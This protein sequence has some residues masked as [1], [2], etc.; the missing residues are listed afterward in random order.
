MSREFFKDQIK[1]MTIGPGRLEGLFNVDP[2][3]EILT[4]N[5]KNLYFSGILFPKSNAKAPDDAAN[6]VVENQDSDEEPIDGVEDA[7]NEGN[8]EEKIER[9]TTSNAD[10][11]LERF[12]PY[13]IGMVFQLADNCSQIK[14]SYQYAKYESFDNLNAKRIRFSQNEKT[15]LDEI[16]NRINNGNLY[17]NFDNLNYRLHEVVQFDDATQELYVNIIPSF[18]LN[19]NNTQLSYTKLV[20]SNEIALQIT[21][22]EK[23]V[24]KKL[25]TL[26]K[27]AYK[28]IPVNADFNVNTNN[29]PIE[30]IINDDIKFGIKIYLRGNKKLA[31]VLML[32]CHQSKDPVKANYKKLLFQTG[33]KVEQKINGIALPLV[34][35]T[36]MKNNAIDNDQAIID[37]VYR[38]EQSYGKGV[39]CAVSWS[40]LNHQG[41]PFSLKT[42]YMPEVE[43]KDFSLDAMDKMENY[44]DVFNVRNISHWQND[45]NWILQ[46]L[47]LFIESYNDWHQ[48]Q[49]G[50]P[51][52]PQEIINRQQQLLH[53]LRDNV[54]YL[55]NNINAMKCF[56]LANTTMF[57]QMVIA[58]DPRFKKN[59]DFAEIAV[60]GGIFDNLEFF[61]NY[62][63]F[64]DD[65]IPKYRPFQLAFLLMNVKP[66][67]DV[68]DIFH[69]DVVDL[70]W[71]PTGGG[72]TEAYLA[73]TALTII[74]RHQLFPNNNA[75]V[76]VIMRYTLRLLAAQQ[77]ERASYLICALEFMRNNGL[78][79][80]S[81]ITAGMWI[82][83]SVTPN[84]LKAHDKYHTYNN[85]IT[86]FNPGQPNNQSFESIQDKNPHPIVCCPW[87][88][89][90]LITQVEGN[91]LKSGYQLNGPDADR[92]L[93][94]NCLNLNCHFNG[95]VDGRRG[96][97]LPLKY[98]DNHIY[99]NPPSLLFGTVDKFAMLSH[100]E[101]GHLLFQ[102]RPN[103]G[104]L[105][106]DLIIQDEL[107]LISGPLGSM[108]GLFETIIE[109]LATKT[110]NGVI[111]KP[112]IIASTATTRNT[113]ALIKNLYNREV[114]VFPAQGTSYKDNFFSRVEED[115]NP[116]GAKRK[117]IGIIPAGNTSVNT[118]IHLVA[119]IL[120][121][122]MKLFENKL[123]EAEI[124]LYDSNAIYNAIQQNQVLIKEFDDYWTLLMYYNSLKDLGRTKS[125]IPQEIREYIKPLVS[126]TF[127][128]PEPLHFILNF[129][130][131][132][133]EFTSRAS[134]NEI[135]KLLKRAES[136]IKLS[137]H[138]G[139]I[140]VDGE[141][142]DLA[143]ASNMISVG[144]DISRFNI[145]LFAGQPRSF[146]E[147]IQSSSR[148]ARQQNGLV[149]NLLN[150]IRSRE[151]SL[152]ENYTAFH[153]SYYKYVEPLSATPFTE[154]VIDRLANS[155]LVCYVRHKLGIGVNAFQ[156]N[157]ANEL[158]E[159][160]IQRFG[161][162]FEQYITDTVNGLA[163]IWV[164]KMPVDAYDYNYNRTNNPLIRAGD[165]DYNL[166]KS[167][168]DVDPDCFLIIN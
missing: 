54:V 123:R 111:H 55:Q 79:N 29:P 52:R 164:A 28:R 146:S 142:L 117:H 33:F 95:Q 93:T 122:K 34:P 50:V 78:I 27:P 102:S 125:R 57:I 30:I 56:K 48:I 3:N 8:D 138:D 72:K 97:T 150:P 118:E 96:R 65:K 82:G 124:D 85:E 77:F 59:R 104:G 139:K 25:F 76:S 46:R 159:K 87:C 136:P 15:V 100:K 39:N 158:K 137:L 155:L 38:N 81:P 106:P 116:N 105:P 40:N 120:L 20:K 49:S 12:A 7:N 51:D 53:R 167:L 107:H 32:S 45:D 63:P 84:K 144:I 24:L 62:L 90:K 37:F 35:Y 91:N 131:R 89:C 103:D 43:V 31:K 163:N 126:E 71:F 149:V 17:Q 160:L 75:G 162:V 154:N 80:G 94:L 148:V 69:G 165:D 9:Q 64:G 10:L 42:T 73:L 26:I 98:V 110:I 166:M 74:A 21:A 143:L 135:K 130:A 47:N 168:R 153:K 147:Y 83:G 2:E 4:E 113:A 152:F 156:L 128:I 129:E 60:D 115:N 5:P 66:T 61:Q 19:G 58:R 121:A 18:I 92:T 86:N 151:L 101:Q 22:R 99:N 13:Y 70:I 109:D 88:G 6:I 133:D 44:A 108:V 114:M 67:L 14:I 134:G 68:T 119:T 41:I 145:M 127:F 157:N 140:L 36:E 112:K 161:L 16:L 1:K 132:S 23:D 141:G 11:W